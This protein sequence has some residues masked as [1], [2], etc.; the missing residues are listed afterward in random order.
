MGSRR[1]FGVTAVSRKAHIITYRVN[2][3][4]FYKIKILRIAIKHNIRLKF[5]LN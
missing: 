5:D 2:R 3:I 4:M 1:L